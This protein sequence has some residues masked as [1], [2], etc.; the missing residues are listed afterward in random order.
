MSYTPFQAPIIGGLLGDDEIA[1][2]FSVKAELVAMLRFEAALARAC[3]G[4]DIIAPAA[5][6]SIEAAIAGYEPD[7]TS[8]RSATARDGVA[9]PELLRQL[10]E[11]LPDDHRD[12]LHFGA[13]S[14]DVIDTSLSLR[15]KQL[16][17]VLAGRLAAIDNEFGALTDRFGTRPMMARTRMKAAL[18]STIGHRLTN[19]RRSIAGAGEAL[20]TDFQA[21]IRLQFGGP[22]GDLRQFGE[23]GAEIAKALAAEL[24]LP[25]DPACWHTDR[26]ALSR[27][28]FSLAALAGAFGKLGQ[29]LALMAQDG[30][31]EAAFSQTGGSSAMAHKQNPVLAETLVTLARF[32]ATLSGGMSQ[33][34]VHE[35]ERSGAAW[36][37]EWLILPQLC[38]AA[39]AATRNAGLLLQSVERLGRP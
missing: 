5:A 20:A 38:V 27:L 8:L 24:D 22:V 31:D 26:V 35:Q 6:E 29:D 10:R 33:A 37:L 14:Q 18:D 19:W 16:A 36:T 15:L 12:A 3:A 39:G 9:V 25:A 4:T 13:T 11:R 7:L 2:L 30:I 23:Q 1:A 17:P 32:T 28:A 21:A 34:V